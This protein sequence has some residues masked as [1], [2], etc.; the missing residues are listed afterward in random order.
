MQPEKRPESTCT[1]Q[2]LHRHEVSAFTARPIVELK[3]RDKSKIESLLIYG[4]TLGLAL[5]RIVLKMVRPRQSSPRW[6][7][8]W[9]TP[10]LS[11]K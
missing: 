9:S 4:D 8:H 11:S 1:A 6:S 10:N 7:Q 5:V 3:Q 2:L